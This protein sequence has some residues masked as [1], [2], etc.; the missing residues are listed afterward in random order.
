MTTE[1]MWEPTGDYQ[2]CTNIIS[3]MEEHGYDSG[4][5]LVPASERDLEAIWGDMASD[6]GIEWTDE[7]DSV[8]DT[9]DGVEFA[10]WFEGGRL[11][12]TNTILDKW[13]A[14]CPDRP[15]Y[16]WVDEDG[17]EAAVTYSEIASLPG[18]R[19]GLDTAVDKIPLS[20]VI[21]TVLSSKW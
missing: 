11:N 16:V 15:M 10:H 17:N 6:V 4:D 2:N 19:T 18:P 7:Y 14:R 12:A 3:F 20:V 5:E 13:V 9:S 21:E 1:R 8:V